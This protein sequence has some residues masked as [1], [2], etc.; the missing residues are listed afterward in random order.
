MQT[1]VLEDHQEQEG[2]GFFSGA[3][4]NYGAELRFVD[5]LWPPS[6]ELSSVGGDHQWGR[7]CP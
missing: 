7:L 3:I 1:N 2:G 4:L 5:A 6:G